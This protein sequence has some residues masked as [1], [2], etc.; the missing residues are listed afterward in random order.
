LSYAQKV[1]LSKNCTKK[2]ANQSAA[3]LL[4][5]GLVAKYLSILNIAEFSNPLQHK[6]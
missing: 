3:D 4:C 5:I 1:L 6:K 2:F